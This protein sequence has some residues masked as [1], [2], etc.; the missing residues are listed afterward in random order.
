MSEFPFR[1]FRKF[2]LTI[3][4][5]YFSK[6]VYTHFWI[7]LW[8]LL[9]VPSDYSNPNVHPQFSK[10]RFVNFSV[11]SLESFS[12]FR[13]ISITIFIS[14]FNPIRFQLF[15][16]IFMINSIGVWVI[17]AWNIIFFVNISSNRAKPSRKG[18]ELEEGGRGGGGGGG[19]RFSDASSRNGR[20]FSEG[21]SG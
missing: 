14:K 12:L 6:Y 20:A 15:Q 10:Y 8:S 11:D 1:L 2:H 9:K 21:T 4:A 7:S 5:I 16:L 19:D 13:R 18:L 3:L 17:V